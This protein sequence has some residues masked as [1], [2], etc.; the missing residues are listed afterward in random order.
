MNCFEYN[1][2]FKMHEVGNAKFVAVV[3]SLRPA[4]YLD[5]QVKENFSLL[6]WSQF[7]KNL[8]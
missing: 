3:I 4:V 5:S 1:D 8:V 7:L 6:I 2:Y